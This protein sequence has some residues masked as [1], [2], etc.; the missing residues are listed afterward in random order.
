MPVLV[1]I[2]NIIPAASLEVKQFQK[3]LLSSTWL[4]LSPE[5]ECPGGS[6]YPG[7]LAILVEEPTKHGSLV[8]QGGQE[9]V[10]LI[11]PNRSQPSTMGHIEALTKPLSPLPGH[12]IVHEHVTLP[13]MGKVS[14]TLLTRL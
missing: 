3:S 1:F 6:I 9:H 5:L 4:P 2:W 12:V 8:G 10:G 7:P 11:V 14:P 13:S